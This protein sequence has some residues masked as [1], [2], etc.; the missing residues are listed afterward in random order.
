MIKMND[1]ARKDWEALEQIDQSWIWKAAVFA[2]RAARKQGERDVITTQNRLELL[3]R[4]KNAF[5]GERCGER[6]GMALYCALISFEQEEQ[7]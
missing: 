1:V 2:D 6:T 5:A 7:K 4:I 3:R